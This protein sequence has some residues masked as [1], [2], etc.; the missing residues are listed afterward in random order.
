M[1]FYGFISVSFDHDDESDPGPCPIPPDALIEGGRHSSG[2][3]HLIVLDHGDCVLYELLPAYLPL[4]SINMT[5][6]VMIRAIGHHFRSSGQTCGTSPRFDKR[7]TAPATISSQ[8]VKLDRIDD[9]SLPWASDFFPAR[10]DAIR[11]AVGV[12]SNLRCN[13]RKI[14]TEGGRN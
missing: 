1:T 10:G 2:D 6:P 5:T 12:H 7:N 13:Q 11:F 3:R 14:N 8:A 9:S 4:R